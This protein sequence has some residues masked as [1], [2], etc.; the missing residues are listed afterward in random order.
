MR[1]K[2]EV[3]ISCSSVVNG[4]TTLLERPGFEPVCVGP[5]FLRLTELWSWQKQNMEALKSG[6]LSNL[7]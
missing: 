5:V 6:D 2:N 1:K 3:T 7:K 4:W